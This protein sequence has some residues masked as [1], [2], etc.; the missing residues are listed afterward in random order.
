MFPEGDVCKRGEEKLVPKG[1]LFSQRKL[2]CLVYLGGCLSLQ[3][4]RYN[5]NFFESLKITCNKVMKHV[6]IVC[7]SVLC[8]SDFSLQKT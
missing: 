8:L 3:R 7:P 5:G 6:D 4:Y 1:M 2:E